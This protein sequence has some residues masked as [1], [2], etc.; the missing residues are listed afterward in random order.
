MLNVIVS[1]LEDRLREIDAEIMTVKP[2]QKPEYFWYLRGR[3]SEL[4]DVINLI[5][6]QGGKWY[7]EYID[8]CMI[9]LH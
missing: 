7:D 5:N 4:K 2:E 9:Q 8:S 1:K 3:Q 6:T